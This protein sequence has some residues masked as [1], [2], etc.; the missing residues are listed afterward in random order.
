[1]NPSRLLFFESVD[2]F[3]LLSAGGA[4]NPTVWG[5]WSDWGHLSVICEIKS[6][7]YL[8]PVFWSYL[9]WATVVIHWHISSINSVGIM[10]SYRL[11]AV[12]CHTSRLLLFFLDIINSLFSSDSTVII[13]NQPIKYVITSSSSWC[14]SGLSLSSILVFTIDHSIASTGA[15]LLLMLSPQ[16]GYV[17]IDVCSGESSWGLGS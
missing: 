12:G 7:G 11:A 9:I 16:T 13:L 2:Q 3:F 17:L 1:M 15:A 4:T 10:E 6:Q 14:H 8:W 5:F